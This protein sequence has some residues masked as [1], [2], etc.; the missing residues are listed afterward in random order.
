MSQDYFEQSMRA[1]QLAGMS[2]RTQQAYTR[3]VRLLVEF[4]A[5]TPEQ[6]TEPELEDYFLH[7]RNVDKWSSAT[8]TIAY[9]GVKFFFE[10]VLKRDWHIF[11][12]LRSQKEHR[13]PSILSREEVFRVLDH[14]KTIQNYT[15]LSTIYACGLRISEALGLEVSDIDG[16]RMMIHVHR[17]KGAK[18][19]YV[20]LPEESYRLLRRYWTT[21]R[22]PTL[23]FPAL[24]RGHNEGGT[25][26]N[27]MAISS[28]QGAFREARFAA[29]IVKRQVSVHTLRHCYATHLLEDGVNP[30]IVQRYMGHSNLETTMMYFHLTQKGTEDAYKIINSTMRGFH[31]DDRK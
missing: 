2:E 26:R 9:S 10:K 21:H 31:Y 1:L 30:R 27:P 16:K 22:H 4:H 13:L 24:G 5:K 14:I 25:A 18:D 19:R 7:R 23:I 28:V 17:G 12:Y 6:I 3:A 11:T 29:S 20:P 8:L 15:C